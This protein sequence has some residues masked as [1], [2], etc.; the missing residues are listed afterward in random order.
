MSDEADLVLRGRS[1]RTLSWLG[2]A[3]FE[4][5]VR[6]RIAARG[7]LPIDRLDAIKAAVVRAESQAE[8]LA[9]IEPELD[10]DERGTVGRARNTAVPSSARGRRNTKDYRAA[11]GLEALVAHWRLSGSEGAARLVGVLAPRIEAAI[12]AAWLRLRNRPRRG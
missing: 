10:D 8:M 6:R 1:I 5:D 12:D 4:D 9:A 11:S 3:M 7:D 2:D